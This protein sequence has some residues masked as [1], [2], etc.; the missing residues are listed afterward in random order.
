MASMGSGYDLSVATFSPD[1]R[2][3]Q[4]EYAAK[5][6]EATGLTIGGVFKDGVV[7]AVDKYLPSKLVE[8]TTNTRVFKVAP[9]VICA[10]AGSLPDARR[11]LK[12]CR[13]ECA[14]YERIWG[15][16][17]TGNVLSERIGLY[18]HA[19]TAVWST[20]PFGCALLLAVADKKEISDFPASGFQCRKE[21]PTGGEAMEDVSHKQTSAKD[22]SLWVVDPTGANYKYRATA[23]AKGNQSAKSDLEKLNFDELTCEQGV[24]EFAKILHTG[25][26]EIR[27][28]EMKVEMIWVRAQDNNLGCLVPDDILDK[29]DEEAR[30]YIERMEIE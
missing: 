12:A 27:E 7:L 13:T 22:F 15:V 25:H 30:A 8:P 9:H 14:E 11:L 10:A 20:R 1:G 5:A 19:H 26:Q 16:P 24:Q 18:V 2:V 6:V 21:L 23:I 17:I 28:R 29:A 4:V 3:F